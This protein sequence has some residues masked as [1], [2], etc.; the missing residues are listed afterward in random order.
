MASSNARAGQ[1]DGASIADRVAARVSHALESDHTFG[2]ASRTLS[3]RVAGEMADVL[4]GLPDERRRELNI[5]SA[6]LMQRVRRTVEGFSREQSGIIA[7]DI[8]D[9]IEPS[10]GEGLGATLSPE[11]GERALDTIAVS[12]RIED[13]AGPVAGATELSR[14]HG[15]ARSSL[16]RWQHDDD[17]I[18]LLKGTRKHVYPVAQFVDG[19][20][21]RGLRDVIALAGSHRVAWLWL[22]QTNPVLSGRR[23]IDLLKQDHVDEVVDA[24]RSYFPPQ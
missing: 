16:N 21:A 9:E 3:A 6:E 14:E 2:D 13:W 7:L 12:R 1:S 22:I 8:P 23:P 15:V 24:A 11:Q 4:A 19:R 18:G 20:P 17:V 5:H 10:K